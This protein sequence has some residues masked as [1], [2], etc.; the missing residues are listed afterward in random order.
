M[1]AIVLF[2]DFNLSLMDICVAFSLLASHTDAVSGMKNL[3]WIAAG[4]FIPVIVTPL[5]SEL[6]LVHGTGNA[7][8]MF[9]QG[10][11]FSIFAALGIV[12][13]T[14]AIIAHGPKRV[15]FAP[16]IEQS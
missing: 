9:F 5:M 1:T 3:R 15:T 12:E 10:L 13:F 7:N 14:A 4:T 8:F 6:W 2:Y 16:T 11:V